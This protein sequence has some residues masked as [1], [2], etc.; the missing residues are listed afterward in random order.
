MSSQQSCLCHVAAAAEYA[1]ICVEQGRK[2]GDLKPSIF[3]KVL[4]Y[5]V[6]QKLLRRNAQKIVRVQ[7]FYQHRAVQVWTNFEKYAFDMFDT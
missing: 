3:A 6:E 7:V 5:I 2:Q 1:N 4:L